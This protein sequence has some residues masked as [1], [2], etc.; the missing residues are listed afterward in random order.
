LPGTAAEILDDEVRAVICPDKIIT[1]QWLEVIE[2]AH[3]QG[4]RSTATI[5][6]GH[7][8]QM[9]HWARH[10]LRLRNLSRLCRCRLDR[11]NRPARAGFPGSEHVE[12][13]RRD[14][15]RL[16]VVVPDS[17]DGSVGWPGGSHAGRPALNRRTQS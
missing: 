15:A 4:L 16:S 14:A 11:E 8:D 9:K 6:F 12:L 5:M 17:G 10:L 7:V 13:R 1:A 3:R 2:T